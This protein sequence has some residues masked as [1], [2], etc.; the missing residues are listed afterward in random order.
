MQ[1]TQLYRADEAVAGP[2][3]AC[4][5]LPAD[6]HYTTENVIREDGTLNVIP[7]FRFD[8]RE[9]DALAREHAPQFA[10]NQPFPHAVFENFLPYDIAD[11]IAREFPRPGDI[12]WRLAGPGDVQ[13]SHDPNIE[14]ISS[15]EEE[16]F[17][18]LIRH[19]MHEF[20]SGTFLGFLS[21]LTQFKMLSPDPSFHGCGLH[22]TGRGGRLMIH[23]DA[24]R[25][26]N[27]KLQQL[28]N[29]IYYATPEWQEAWG[30]HFELWSKD[31]SECVKR[32]TPKF[33]SMLVFFTGSNSYHGHPQPLTT[34]PGIRR[35]S[36][37]AYFYTTDRVADEDY[38]GYKNYVEWVR[39]SDL[40]RNVSVLHRGKALV[41][42]LLPSAVV[43]RV[44]TVVRRTRGALSGSSV[45][46]Q[47][48]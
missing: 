12:T 14:K 21:T 20:N 18:P 36:L 34:P 22:S 17:P 47:N 13:H 25:H 4:H 33:N 28:L 39:T 8:R 5:D 1:P 11:A 29:V 43:N 38:H 40:D 37:A 10:A 9:L 42:R 30:G 23:A 7:A 31:R 35:N 41:R 32:V 44:A 27:P 16:S 15:A 48:R 6:L 24:S 46:S 45:K 3:A 19:V 26:P 2:S